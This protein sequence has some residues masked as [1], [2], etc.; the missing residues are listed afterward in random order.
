MNK[1]IFEQI[2]RLKRQILPHERVILFGSQARGDS[3]PD[4]DW[5]LLILL[6]NGKEKRTTEDVDNYAYPFD[7][8]GWEY[9]ICINAIVYTTKQ[10]ERGRIFPFY[11]N[12][13]REGIEIK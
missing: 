2:S 13:M 10:W 3:H 11:R 12:V 7:E 8:L 6:D 1:A 9:G 4:S 5:D